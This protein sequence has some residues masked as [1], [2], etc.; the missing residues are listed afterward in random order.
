MASAL[1]IVALAVYPANAATL[2]AQDQKACTTQLALPTSV[3]TCER[4]GVTPKCARLLRSCHC[5][6]V[7]MHEG[8]HACVGGSVAWPLVR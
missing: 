7:G 2:N 4:Y 8:C 1:V 3:V 5:K 6:R